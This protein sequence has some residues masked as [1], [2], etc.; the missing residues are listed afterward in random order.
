MEF[1]TAYILGVQRRSDYFGE[2][3]A[4]YRSVDTISV[5]GYIDVRGS[6]TDYKGVQQAISQID[7]YVN[8]ASNPSVTENIIINGTGFGT[9]RIVNLD[10]PAS[11][12]VDENQIRFGKYTADIEI[13]NSGDLGNVFESPTREITSV[14]GD[15]TTDIFTKVNHNL[16]DGQ[17]LI[18]TSWSMGGGPTFNRIYYVGVISKNTFKLYEDPART[19]VVN[20]TTPIS[21][22]TLVVYG[23]VPFPEYLESFSEDFTVSL[24]QSNTYNFS[25]NLDITY[26]SGLEKGG[27]A[28]DPIATA[29][30]LAVNLFDQTPTQFSTVIPDSYG[31]ISA[32]ARE[33]YNENYDLV[34]GSCGFEKTF[35]LL[36]SG[37]STYSLS[38]SNTF[39]FDEG[40]IVKVSERGD[41]Q[42][43][44]PEFLKEAQDA[45]DV[46]IG[47]SYERCSSIYDSYKNYLGTNVGVLFN[48]AVVKNKTINNS[49]GTSSY[50]VEYTDDL[51]IK[52]LNTLTARSLSIELADN[53]Y[54]VSEN[55]TVTSINTKSDNFDPYSL[56]PE[57]SDVKTRC[58]NFYNQEKPPSNQH[59]L[60]NLNNKFSI[61]KYGKEISYTYTFTSD[62]NVFD[63]SDDAVFARKN[64]QH[65]DKIGTPNQSSMIIPN[66]SSAILHTPGQTSLGTRST[67]FQGELR[68]PQFTS[69][70][71][72]IGFPTSAITTAKTEALQ[73]AYLVFA[74][75]NGNL[76]LRSLDKGQIYVTSANYSFGA[77]SAFNLS[78]DSTFTMVRQTNG[79]EFNLVFQPD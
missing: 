56:I 26:I 75:V 42:P 30:C 46:E 27:T 32:T 22:A 52:D 77:D 44:S 4:Q 73:D 15:D 28:I 25:H 20:I 21:N 8:S 67:K 41:V 79:A 68:R 6:N 76:L 17:E 43:R 66:F 29:K 74:S 58:V 34:N 1:T 11:Q 69:R 19:T 18:I 61:P 63:R 16:L 49:E 70:L 24:D 50:S 45:L 62:G 23:L 55:G 53:I 72:S 14:G 33:Y 36:P 12:G 54:T 65:S 9:G 78:I 60:K 2:N 71:D 5:E 38:V 35:S 31:S 10:F 64:I 48:Q 39:E 47:K 37:L 51:K 13:Y 59:T 3:V 40:G 7:T 57:R